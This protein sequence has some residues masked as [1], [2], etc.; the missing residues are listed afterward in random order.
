M[1]VQQGRVR[2]VEAMAS[3]LRRL[4]FVDIETTGLDPTSEE[5]IEIGAVFVERGIV[6][7]RRRWLVHPTRPIPALITALTGLTDE[8]VASAPPL[9]S[10]DAELRAALGGWTLVAH[11][12]SFERSFLGERIAQNVMLDS[13]EVAQLLFPERASHSLDALVRWLN[14]GRAA[15]HR[16]LDDAEDTFLVLAALCDRVLQEKGR[17]RLERLI[18]H[19]DGGD[20]AMCS[21][22]EALRTAPSR[23]AEP[24]AAPELSPDGRRLAAHLARWLEAPAFVAAELERGDLLRIGCEAGRRAAGARGEPVAVAVSGGTFREL[25]DEAPALARHAVCS[26]ALWAALDDRGIDE[27]SRFARAYLTSWLTRT[28]TGDLD[29][30][31]GFVRSKCPEVMPLLDS[32]AACRCD[33]PGCLARRSLGEEPCVLIT[34]E[35]ALDWLERGAPVPLLFLEADRLPE[36]E[37]R[38]TQRAL[39]LWQLERFGGLEA[40]VTELGAA[41]AAFPPGTVMM[42]ARVSPEWHAIREAMTH[43]SHT[44]RAAPLGDE[45]TK[46]L[47][48][49]VEVLEPPP[50]GHE[51]QVSPK[52]LVRTP[53]APGDRVRRRL[54]RGHVLISSFHGGLSWTK[55]AP[56]GMP[57]ERPGALL[58]WLAEPTSL[59][60]LAELVSRAGPVVLVAP[61]PLGPIA[62]ACQRQGLTVS[63]DAGRA[64]AV[65]L[66]EWRRDRAMPAG[67]T[68]VFYGVREWRRAVLSSNAPRVMLVSP[69]GLSQEPISRALQGLDPRPFTTC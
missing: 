46:L 63:L 58:E 35:H 61:S 39:E 48:R 66:C 52:G 25:T 40:H 42:R 21:L 67:Q 2:G 32:A 4:C 43:L 16:A 56:V 29:G 37:R 60:R 38:R 51:V 26:T 31:S 41:L 15:R 53:I 27:R 62:E 64:S 9:E 69:T 3:I 28:R 59:E 50:P 14:I 24:A 23:P 17:E 7:E 44:L 47:G 6:T 8:E 12:A 45:R 55:A 33:Q 5:I 65:Q 49:I 10:I 20:T 22:F 11:N 57:T 18:F 54:T 13:C 34:H 30:I 36:V 19:L 68:C 1:S